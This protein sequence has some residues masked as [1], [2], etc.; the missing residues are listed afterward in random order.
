MHFPTGPAPNR[1]AR[2]EAPML[3]SSRAAYYLGTDRAG[4]EFWLLGPDVFSG[5]EGGAPTRHVCALA[6]FNRRSRSRCRRAT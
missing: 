3:A 1:F 6:R 2:K 4:M 5:A